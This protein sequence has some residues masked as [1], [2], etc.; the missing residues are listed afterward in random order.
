M[1]NLTKNCKRCGS[2]FTLKPD[3][4]CPEKWVSA[5]AATAE[6]C[7]RCADF[8]WARLK[9]HEAIIWNATRLL[10]NRRKQKPTESDKSEMDDSIENIR[11]LLRA[12]AEKVC[13][14]HKIRFLWDETLID[15]L[16]EK[17]DRVEVALN[18]Y[19]S[20]VRGMA[21]DKGILA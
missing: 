9:L 7:Q 12:L 4:E 19:E 18:M 15:T 8:G 14:F 3:I 1:D 11:T 20:G 17:P 2:V 5:L 6:L 21:K 13:S 16:I 10:V